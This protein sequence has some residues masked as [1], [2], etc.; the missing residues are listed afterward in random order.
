[1]M[2]TDNSSDRYK[3]GGW[4]GPKPP[5]G[6]GLGQLEHMFSYSPAL[7]T[8]DIQTRRRAFSQFVQKSPFALPSS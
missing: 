7:I 1:M 8:N 4:P 2:P 5:K 6:E 3:D